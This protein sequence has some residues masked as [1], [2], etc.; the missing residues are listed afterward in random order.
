MSEEKTT[1]VE[2][3]AECRKGVIRFFQ[4]QMPPEEIL[5]LVTHVDSCF[6][7]REYINTLSTLLSRRQEISR[8]L[9]RGGF[10]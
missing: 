1:L 7:C 6:D 9:R 2:M 4:L 8:E 5:A 3:K 10:S